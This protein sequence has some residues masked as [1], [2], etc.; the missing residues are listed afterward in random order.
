MG[1]M[2]EVS[3]KALEDIDVILDY[4]V[5]RHGGA[6]ALVYYTDLKVKFE[7]LADNPLICRE[8][9]EFSPSQCVSM[10]T[11]TTLSST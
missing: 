3:E 11:R 8:R 6:Q 10:S 9:V 4:T 2:Y 7:T 1:L 5:V